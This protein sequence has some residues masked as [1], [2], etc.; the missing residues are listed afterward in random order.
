MGLG[1]ADDGAGSAVAYAI[2]H[3]EDLAQVVVP[4]EEPWTKE[5]RTERPKRNI[6]LGGLGGVEKVR[7]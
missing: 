7:V 3:D 1:R 2:Y 5:S 6:T 4:D